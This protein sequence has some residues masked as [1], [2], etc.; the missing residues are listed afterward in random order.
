MF[1]LSLFDAVCNFV[2]HERCIANLKVPCRHILADMIQVRERERER[3][4][5]DRAGGGGGGGGG[6]TYSRN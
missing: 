4:G 2:T 5:R 6:G 3:E 1:F